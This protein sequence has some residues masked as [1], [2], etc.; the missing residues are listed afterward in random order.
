MFQE[1]STQI[2]VETVKSVNSQLCQSLERTLEES[3]DIIAQ[4]Q[5]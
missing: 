5:E 1:L 2:L 4:I 3:Q